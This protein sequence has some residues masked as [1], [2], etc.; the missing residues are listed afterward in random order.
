MLES[1]DFDAISPKNE[2][3]SVVSSATITET[4]NPYWLNPF[5]EHIVMFASLAGVTFARLSEATMKLDFSIHY[6]MG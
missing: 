2:S 3:F 1:I 5:M 4:W 6:Q